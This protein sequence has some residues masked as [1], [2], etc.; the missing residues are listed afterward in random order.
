MINAF[1][2]L[3]RIILGKGETPLH[4]YKYQRYIIELEA[5]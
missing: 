4:S 3:G 5:K 2:V 1:P